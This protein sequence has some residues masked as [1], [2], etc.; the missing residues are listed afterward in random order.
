VPDRG[1]SGD[2]GPDPL[3]KPVDNGGRVMAELDPSIIQ[4]VLAAVGRNFAGHR[5]HADLGGHERV[6]EAWS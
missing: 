4:S 3:A 2:A 5:I 1:Q 6:L